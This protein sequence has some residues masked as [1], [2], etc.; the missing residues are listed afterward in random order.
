M[1]EKQKKQS[2]TQTGYD[3]LKAELD[4][5]ENE[6]MP[7]TSKKIQEAKE[8]GDLSENAE[9]DAARE[10]QA[11]IVAR[12]AEIKNIL[13]NSEVSEKDNKNKTKVKLES[14]VTVLDV[15]LGEEIAYT[16]VGPSEVNALEN[17]ISDESPLGMAIMGKKKGDSVVINAPAGE[18]EYR[19]LAVKN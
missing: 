14:I 6:K 17:K 8:Q 2:I 16:I 11:K 7:D 12:I 9:Y 1:E 5:L 3:E 10:E 15:E 4:Y 18:L 19:I 13:E